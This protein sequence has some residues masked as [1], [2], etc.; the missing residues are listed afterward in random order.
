MIYAARAM[1][2]FGL[3][4]LTE[5]NIVKEA[6]AEFDIEAA[7]E[8]YICPIPDGILPPVYE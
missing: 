1:A 5:P 6:K 7:G 3:K 2:L 8:P 4:V